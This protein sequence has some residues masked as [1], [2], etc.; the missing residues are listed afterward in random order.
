MASN[1]QFPFGS[2]AGGVYNGGGQ[3]SV[4]G[5]QAGGRFQPMGFHFGQGPMPHAPT[6]PGAAGFQHGSGAGAQGDHRM[7]RGERSSTERPS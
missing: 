4:S 7:G 6:L 2:G 3:P 1:N 5:P